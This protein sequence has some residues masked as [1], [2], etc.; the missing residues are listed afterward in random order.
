MNAESFRQLYDYHFS[1]NR[2]L[3]DA[4]VMRLSPE[5]W[6]QPIAYSNGSIA[7]HLVH[8]AEVEDS[9]FSEL[10]GLT[11]SSH[12]FPDG[13]TDRDQ[14]RAQWDKVE[15][16]IRAYLAD[17]RD[18]QL[19]TQPIV[20]EEDQQLRVWQVLIHVVNH[21]TDHRAQVRRLL[22]DFGITTGP[23]DFIFY[24]YDHS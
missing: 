15:E 17:L 13:I 3:W 21:G 8:L 14:I 18:D 19:F 20:F 5:Q 7:N 12:P 16:T 6:T 24:A 10:R 11:E 22:H 2:R 9:W 4:Y 1:E 23:Q